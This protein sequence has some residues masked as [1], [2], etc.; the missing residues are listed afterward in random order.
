MPQL[1]LIN[2]T[3]EKEA[4]EEVFPILL[5]TFLIHFS[6]SWG[7]VYLYLWKLNT[8]P[9]VT[10]ENNTEFTVFCKQNQFSPAYC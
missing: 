4:R 2:I 8:V 6:S 10:P 7:I 9:Q 1:T 5:H 3:R